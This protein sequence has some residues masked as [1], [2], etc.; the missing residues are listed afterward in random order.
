MIHLWR[1]IQKST[2]LMGD[3]NT[4]PLIEVVGK[5]SIRW[6]EFY[7][8]GLLLVRG[9]MLWSQIYHVKYQYQKYY[10]YI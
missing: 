9:R 3:S 1:D 10:S 5:N 7:I 6:G 8:I 4:N 2:D